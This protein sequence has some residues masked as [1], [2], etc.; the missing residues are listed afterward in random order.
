MRTRLERMIG[1]L[2]EDEDG[3][4][5]FV[6]IK[7]N[8]QRLAEIYIDDVYFQQDAAIYYTTQCIIDSNLTF[9]KIYWSM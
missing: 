8:L 2:F 9:L 4:K 5:L 1:H 7:S 3:I 6:L